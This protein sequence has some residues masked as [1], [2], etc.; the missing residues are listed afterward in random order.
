MKNTSLHRCA[1]AEA[2]SLMRAYH[3]QEWGV[4]D[5]DSRSLWETLMLEGFQAGLS[6][7]TVL[8]KRVP[9]C[10]PTVRSRRSG[11]SQ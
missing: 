8:R 2:D 3:D 1:W 7:I 11:P 6:W 4:P 10:V 9:Y 5:L